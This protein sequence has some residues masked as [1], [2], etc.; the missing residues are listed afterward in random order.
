MEMLPRLSTLGRVAITEAVLNFGRTQPWTVQH[1]SNVSYGR[2]AYN[3]PE[4]WWV[5]QHGMLLTPLGPWPVASCLSPDA[6]PVPPGFP[7]PDVTTA[8]ARRL[9]MVESLDDLSYDDWVTILE[10]VEKTDDIARIA[11][12]YSWACRYITAPEQL[13]VAV[14]QELRHVPTKNVCVVSS[15]EASRSMRELGQPVLV[16]TDREAFTDLVEEWGITDGDDAVRYTMEAAPVGEPV[17]ILD[18]YPPLR[19]FLSKDQRVTSPA[20]RSHLRDIS[21]TTTN[22]RITSTT[23]GGGTSCTC[24]PTS[25]DNLMAHPPRRS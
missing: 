14:G 12:A 20:T 25:F 6:D 9:G 23:S 11:S 10:A 18:K 5:S 1:R 19:N 4:Y 15:H 2:N 21:V 22:G 3:P 8:Q 16:V 13:R 17:R 7:V 24:C